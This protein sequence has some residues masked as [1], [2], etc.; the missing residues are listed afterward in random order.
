[1]PPC[2]IYVAP[3]VQR[4]NVWLMPTTGVSC[5]NAAKTQNPL[6]LAGVPQ[7][8]GP[9][10]AASRPKFTILRGHLES[11]LLLN[12]FFP[13]VDMCLSWKDIARKIVRWCAD[14]DFLR[15]F[16]VLYFER[17]ACSTFQTCIINSHEGHTTCRSMVDIRSATA[18]IRRGKKEERR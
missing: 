11:I 5:S 14:G 18:E 6:K 7:T 2:R 4:H 1:M 8:T 3:S 10:S 15:H 17:A 9:I 16:G 13:I 12:K